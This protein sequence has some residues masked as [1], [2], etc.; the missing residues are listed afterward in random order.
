[1]QSQLSERTVPLILYYSILTGFVTRNKLDLLLNLLNNHTRK[2]DTNVDNFNKKEIKKDII[3]MND[4][5]KAKLETTSNKNKAL[6][7][8]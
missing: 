5:K 1:M 4:V 8:G 2:T 3:V 6:I 7:L